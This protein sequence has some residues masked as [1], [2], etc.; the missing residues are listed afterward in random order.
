MWRQPCSEHAARINS[1]MTETVKGKLTKKD[2]RIARMLRLVPWVAL[3]LTSVP[4]PLSFFAM[5]LASAT[6]DSAAV[7]LL[8]SGVALGFGLLAG[9]VV[10]ILLLLYRKR[11][12]SKL[13]DRLAADGITAREVIWFERELTKSEREIR[14]E[15]AGQN[16]VL[17]DA[18]V[19]TLAARLTASRIL[20]KVARELVKVRGR[21][22]QA[23]KIALANT[24]S[25]QS[26]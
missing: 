9:I 7:Y 19:E 13:R 24:S 2:E 23:R 16:P 20:A 26:D 22:N 17:A 4:L 8:L 14:R 25:L 11:W 6:T 12:F 15:L 3:L 10:L 5:F 1:M 21:I 18:Y